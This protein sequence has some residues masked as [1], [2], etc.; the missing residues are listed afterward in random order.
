[1]VQY[2]SKEYAE[3]IDIILEYLKKNKIS[4][5]EVEER[6]NYTSLSKAKNWDKYPQNIIE[7]LTRQ[8]LFEKLLKEYGLIYSEKSHSVKPR[9]IEIVKEREEDDQ[10]FIMNYFAFARDTIGR[11]IVRIIN[12]RHAVIDYRFDEHWEGTFEIIENYTF[13]SVE[14]GGEVTP[15]KKLIC[16]FSGTKKTGRPYLFGTYSTVKRD[17]IPAAGKV[18]FEKVEK[19]QI[20]RVLKSDVDPRI[21]HY[22]LNKVYVTETF[23]PNTLDDISTT[24]RMINRFA[25]QYYLFYP[26]ANNELIR[27]DLSCT[28]ESR[29]SLT[30]KGMTYSGFLKPVDNHTIRMEFSANPGFAEIYANSIVL[31]TNISKSIYD[32]FYLCVGISNALETRNNSFTCMIIEKEIYDQTPEESFSKILSNL[33][34]LNSVSNI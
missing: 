1:M 13:I 23:T 29:A 12:N 9:G 26:K 24:F 2:S 11:A 31:F 14:K 30:I 21:Y 33:K 3:R 22:L 34:G 19:N 5:Y 7:K 27:S 25:S 18:F 8:E 28:L 15:V 6:L 10:Y 4:Q 17:G 16:L 32:P 20:D